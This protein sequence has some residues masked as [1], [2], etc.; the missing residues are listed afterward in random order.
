MIRII[1]VGKVIYTQGVYI[2]CRIN[3][4]DR[5]VHCLWSFAA[6]M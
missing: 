6:E 2:V 4:H 1:A 3:I 5:K